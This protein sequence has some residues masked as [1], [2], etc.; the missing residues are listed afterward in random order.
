MHLYP[1]GS[2]IDSAAV[3]HSFWL[4]FL[5]DLTDTVAR[6]G[7]PNRGGAALAL[8][9]L[10]T[11]VGAIAAF[12]LILPALL[13]GRRPVLAGCIRIA[14]TVSAVG[15]AAVPFSSGPLHAT[16][17]IA[18]A[19]PGFAAAV[20]ALAGIARYA[21]APAVLALAILTFAA[22]A[23]DLVLYLQS[24]GTHPRVIPAALPVVQRL[25]F[26]LLLA[27]MAVVSIRVLRD[28][29]ATKGR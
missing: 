21:R 8:A 25:G 26:L 5:C 28:A 24:V 29:E 23:A 14:G 18:A 20:L 3:G 12:W 1:G 13:P 16:A 17:L 15:L 10:M 9:A 6:N 7:Q 27:W 19:I 2:A 4:N 11:F 22:A